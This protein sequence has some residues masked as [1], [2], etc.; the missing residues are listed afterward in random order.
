MNRGRSKLLPAL[1]LAAASVA[2]VAAWAP[3]GAHADVPNAKV[4]FIS[5]PSLPTSLRHSVPRVLSRET[6]LVSRSSYVTASRRRNL[7]PANG[8][9]IRQVGVHQGAHVIAVAGYGGRGRNR[10][11][12]LRYYHGGT[13]VELR[14]RT[15]RMRGQ[16]ITPRLRAAILADVRLVVSSVRNGGDAEGEPELQSREL[17]EEVDGDDESP[18][19]TE[20]P[21]PRADTP[22][23]TGDAAANMTRDWGFDITAGFGFG[24]RTSAVPVE[25][26]EGRF[27]S[28][29]FAAAHMGLD[30][31]LR[32]L[33]NSSFRLGLSTRYYS[34]VGLSAQELL[35]DGTVMSVDS[36][37]H[38]LS[39][40][41]SA[42]LAFTD[43][44]RALRMN[45]ELGW[46]FR[47]LDTDVSIS[48]PSYRLSGPQLRVGFF[49]PLGENVPLILGVTPE[50]G[51]VTSV[52]EEVAQAGAISDGFIVGFEAQV[53]YELIPELSADVIYRES[54]AILSSDREGSMNDVERFGVL[55]LT[56][57]P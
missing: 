23:G 33:D 40:G 45:A 52:S 44:A 19:E 24:H 39:I 36:H 48:M 34:S 55:R 31:W 32:P 57:R 10:V 50:L 26:G 25:T 46:F 13:G 41:V 3:T 1:C 49:L 30:I 21:E 7:A 56:Y 43:G 14:A 47:M 27:D 16:T 2:S 51:L 6:R 9:A 22:E 5:A 18:Q 37:A 20:A 35:A 54:H 15:H 17:E 29:P 28:S 12:R 4:L 53:R 42:D 8:R 38:D 11:L